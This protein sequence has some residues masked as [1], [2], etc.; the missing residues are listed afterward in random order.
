MNV[1][2]GYAIIDCTG[3]DL[4]NLGTVNGLYEKAKAAISTGKPLILTGVVNSTQK[5]TDMTAYGGVE[6]ATSVFLSFFPVTLH[7]SNQNVV[8][9]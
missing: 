5:F 2:G 9:M 7:I 4:G 6:S 8:S 3:V 1:K